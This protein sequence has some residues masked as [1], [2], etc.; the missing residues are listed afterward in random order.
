MS[1]IAAGMGLAIASVL[2]LR[3]AWG[4]PRRSVVANGLA[5]AVLL[6][7]LLCG[8]RAAGAWGLAMV[9]VSAITTALLCLAQ[10]ALAAP[11][12][13]AVASRRR[14][15]AL[16]PGP[17]PWHVGRRLLT[18]L[19]VGPV[20]LAASLLAGLGLRA[21]ASRA[22]MGEADADM[23]VLLGMPL[24]W[25][26]MLTLQLMT[27][28]RRTQILLAIVPALTGGLLLTVARGGA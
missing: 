5:W 25:T 2:M 27:P 28:L 23:A 19:L 12:G 22:G 3:V 4:R 10:A 11:P 26:L 24:L 16:P 14:A 15:G 20:G 18:F 6:A 13:K 8:A 1:L 21:L 7:A 17:E 9:S